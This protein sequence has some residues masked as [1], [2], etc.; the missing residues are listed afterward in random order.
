MNPYPL[1]ALNHL[2]VPCSVAAFPAPN[3][4]IGRPLAGASGKLFGALVPLPVTKKGRRAVAQQPSRTRQKES[5]EQQTQIN[6]T[7]RPTSAAT[8]PPSQGREPGG[9]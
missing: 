6:S 2:T 8:P 4:F 9:P 7:I 3:S 5:Q 1:A